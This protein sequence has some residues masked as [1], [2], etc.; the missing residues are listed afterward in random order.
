MVA[1]SNPAGGTKA[2]FMNV[3]VEI[4]KRAPTKLDRA[5]GRWLLDK[6]DL[7]LPAGFE[8]VHEAFAGIGFV[9]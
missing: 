1:G 6:R 5:K 2:I 7:A 9:G 8:V 3:A 4:I